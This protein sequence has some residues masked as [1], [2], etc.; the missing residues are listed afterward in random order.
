MGEQL[1]IQSTPD[2]E[3]M[4]RQLQ[5]LREQWQLLKQMAANQSKAAGGLR[6]LQEFNQKAEQLEAWIRRK[7]HQG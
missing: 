6:N 7:V 2:A 4:R 1:L 5:T 3:T